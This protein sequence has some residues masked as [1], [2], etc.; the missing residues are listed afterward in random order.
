M[1]CIRFVLF[2]VLIAK[3][4]SIVNQLVSRTVDI[5]T[6]LI[7]ERIV[8]L[9]SNSDN[10]TVVSYKFHLDPD[11]DTHFIEFATA[12]HDPLFYAESRNE[13]YVIYDV[14]LDTELKKQ[15]TYMLRVELAY[16]GNIRPFQKGRKFDESQ[17]ML[18][19]GNFYFYSPY[20]TSSLTVIYV[21]KP[22]SNLDVDI[23]PDKISGN[24]V[25]YKFINVDSYT[26]EMLKMRFTSNDPFL[27]V[28]GLFR[29]IDVSH[30]GKISVEDRVD[31][32][33]E[34]N[35]FEYINKMFCFTFGKS[36]VILRLLNY[37]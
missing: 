1:K 9:F 20:F 4:Q 3:S 32:K 30:Y 13:T 22:N 15:E 18:Y 14:A 8:I 6:P 21:C 23:A 2:C 10:R 37:L 26:F 33:N 17:L 29:T 12:K 34:G 25:T 16:F 19:K 24:N 11:I 27:V 35:H 7:K 28:K 5:T 31:V 36:P